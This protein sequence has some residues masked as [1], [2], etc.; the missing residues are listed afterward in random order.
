LSVPLEL[1]LAGYNNRPTNK[2]PDARNFSHY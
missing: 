2:H 1:R